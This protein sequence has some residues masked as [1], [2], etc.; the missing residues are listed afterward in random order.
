[1]IAYPCR[2][3]ATITNFLTEDSAPATMKLTRRRIRAILQGNSVAT[4]ADR[5]P[6]LNW[7]VTCPFL[8]ESLVAPPLGE[9]FGALIDRLTHSLPNWGA[10][11][12]FPARRPAFCGARDSV[13]YWGN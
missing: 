11:T 2:D 3:L 4:F 7:G 5:N 1:M 12:A 6:L 9:P 13:T 8:V 10:D